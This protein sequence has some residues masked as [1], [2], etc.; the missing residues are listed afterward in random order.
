MTNKKIAIYSRKSKYTETGSSTINQIKMC[1]KYLINKFGPSITKNIVVFE[2]EGFTGSNTNRPQFQKMLQEFTTKEYEMLIVYRLD[3]IS[4]NVLDFCSL[5]DTLAELKIDFCS[6]TENF[7]TKTPLGSAMIMISSV[8]AQLERDTIAERIK[9]NMLELA[10]TG[11]WLGGTTPLGY[12]SEKKETKI[13]NSKKIYYELTPIT[14][15]INIVKLIFQKYLEF[16]SISKIEYYLKN[17]Q[18]KTRQ[19]KYFSRIAIIS[20]LKNISYCQA[21]K[22]ILKYLSNQKIKVYAKNT[23]SSHKSFVSYNKRKVQKTKNGKNRK[24]IMN[25]QKD[26]IIAISNH[27]GII[28]G[29]D[30]LTI[31]Q[32]LQ[33]KT[34][35]TIKKNHLASSILKDILHCHQC[36]KKMQAKILKTTDQLGQRNFTYHCQKDCKEPN[37]KGNF[38]NKE[39]IKHLASIP[40][41]N[42]DILEALK[43]FFPIKDVENN[44]LEE[45]I[46]TNQNK[47]HNL[48]EKLPYLDKDIL[49]LVNQEIKELN[50]KNKVLKQNILSSK[51]TIPQ[52][53]SLTHLIQNPFD[54]FFNLDLYDQR[55]LLSLII[56]CITYDKSKIYI[57]YDFRRP[58]I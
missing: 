23:A 17:H 34:H 30:W 31:N 49:P 20:I 54:Y 22:D 9:D 46:K 52:R 11:R 3:R 4:R 6:I 32:E 10:K 48:I 42:K 1:K 56:K 24:N 37:I 7:D 43:T 38:L 18:I 14:D 41:K 39:I 21:D 50:D 33:N 28:S 15:E 27:P 19:N 44:S 57:T 2:D 12:K 51:K 13:N 55:K 47:I 40:T 29:K 25:N 45:I 5:K 53:L 16:H 8:F 36:Q 26:W 58:S 35:Q